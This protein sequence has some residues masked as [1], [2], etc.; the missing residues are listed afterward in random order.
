MSAAP[1]CTGFEKRN[2]PV[3]SSDKYRDD[4]IAEEGPH[5]RIHVEDGK[6]RVISIV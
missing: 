1:L 2:A 3:G 6:G 4:V 5:S